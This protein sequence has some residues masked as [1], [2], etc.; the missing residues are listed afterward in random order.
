M[1][2]N[3]DILAITEW[4]KDLPPDY[5][6]VNE[7][8]HNRQRLA[9]F[10]YEFASELGSCRMVWN[11]YQAIT[12]VKKN[13]Y[14]NDYGGN[15][16][17]DYQAREMVGPELKLEKQAEGLY[18]SMKF[19]LESIYEILSAMSQQIAVLRQEIDKKY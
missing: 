13:R 8:I 9:G 11:Q 1:A 12:E 10:S 18:Y 14:R 7:L 17:A 19:Q 16:K 5:L 15:T 3:E 6:G 4:Y 2:F